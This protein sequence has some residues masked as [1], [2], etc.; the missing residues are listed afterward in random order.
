MTVTETKRTDSAIP[1][2]MWRCSHCDL[3]VQEIDSPCGGCGKSFAAP[4]SATC[5]SLVVQSETFMEQVLPSP[6][7]T[8][9]ASLED[10]KARVM[11]QPEPDCTCLICD[12]P[13]GMC[14]CQPAHNV[15]A[16]VYTVADMEARDLLIEAQKIVIESL[17][18]RHASTIALAVAAEREARAS[19]A[20]YGYKCK[21]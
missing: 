19:L 7:S 3:I 4:M 5:Y 8:H 21:T 6:A 1:I 18:Q 10:Y 17:K 15:N 12:E 2:G 14:V 13:I 20:E 9:G 16:Y 11:E